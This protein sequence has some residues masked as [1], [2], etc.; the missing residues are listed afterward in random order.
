M[1]YEATARKPL[2]SALDHGAKPVKHGIPGLIGLDHVGITVP[3]VKLA[4]RW[5]EKNLGAHAPLRFGPIRI[6]PGR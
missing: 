5:L 2:W 1:A 4:R 6:R 3:D